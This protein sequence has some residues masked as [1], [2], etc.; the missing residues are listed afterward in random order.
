M[1]RIEYGIVKLL[2]IVK[3][4][5]EMLNFISLAKNIRDFS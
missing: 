1:I 2:F 5:A 4:R 3:A